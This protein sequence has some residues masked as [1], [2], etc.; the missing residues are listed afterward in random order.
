M[1]KTRVTS[2]LEP[3]S[4]ETHIKAKLHYIKGCYLLKTTHPK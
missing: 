2:Q 1:K 3:Y 4:H